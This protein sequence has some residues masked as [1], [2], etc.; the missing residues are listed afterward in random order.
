MGDKK[1]GKLDLNTIKLGSADRILG[2]S[3][4]KLDD[5]EAK[6]EIWSWDGFHGE[7]LVF[8]SPEVEELSDKKLCELIKSRWV[9]LSE[10]LMNVNREPKL[11]YVSWATPEHD[12]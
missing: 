6:Y 4:L 7:S 12:E 3:V 10:R 9:N 11:T 2:S 8:R 5:I 1:T